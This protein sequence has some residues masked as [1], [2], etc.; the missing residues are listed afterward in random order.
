MGHSLFKLLELILRY[1]AHQKA[2]WTNMK[3]AAEFGET[4]VKNDIQPN[5]A[6]IGTAQ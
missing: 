1:K 2:N 6:R 3:P 4:D 5:T